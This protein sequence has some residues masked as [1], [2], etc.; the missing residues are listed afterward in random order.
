MGSAPGPVGPPLTDRD[1]AD[2]MRAT[3][4]QK[5]S[6]GEFSGVAL[7]ARGDATLLSNAWGSRIERRRRR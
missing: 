4:D 6:A 5:A 7:L 3:L 2:H 1:A